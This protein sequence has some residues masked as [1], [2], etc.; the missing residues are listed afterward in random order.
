MMS[1]IA[2]SALDLIGNTFIKAEPLFC[3]GG[4]KG[5]NNLRKAGVFK[6]GRLRKGSYRTGDDRGCGEEG[7]LKT[8][9][10]HY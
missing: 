10:N 9:R 8:G 2:E 4:R 7:H 1:K 6:P 3:G 5:R